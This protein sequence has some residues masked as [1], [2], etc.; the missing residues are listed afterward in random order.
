MSELIQ[1]ES[2]LTQRYQTTIPYV[3]RQTL[4]LEKRISSRKYIRKRLSTLVSSKI[5]SAISFIF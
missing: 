3:V 1:A 5:F 2:T 4:G